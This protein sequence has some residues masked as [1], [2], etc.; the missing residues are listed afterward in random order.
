[1]A[2]RRLL[3]LRSRRLRYVLRSVLLKESVC[4]SE[5]SPSFESF[6][7]HCLCAEVSAGWRVTDSASFVY[8]W[9]IIKPKRVILFHGRWSKRRRSSLL[10][11]ITN[12]EVGYNVLPNDDSADTA[13]SE[14]NQGCPKL[15]LEQKRIFI[16]S[17]QCSRF[18]ECNRVCSGPTPI[19]NPR[20]ME[21]HFVVVMWPCWQTN[22]P[23]NTWEKNITSRTKF[24][25]CS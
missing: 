17:S 16:T 2:R 13:H 15:R 6:T 7:S 20:F 19:L 21:I 18:P 3:G 22:K 4:Y 10:Q 9:G 23:A 14:W 24:I 5:E 12:P 1:M 8:D 25:N 11:L